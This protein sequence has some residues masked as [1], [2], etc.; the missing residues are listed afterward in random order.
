MNTNEHPHWNNHERHETTRKGNTRRR[1][2]NGPRG[3]GRPQGAPCGLSYDLFPSSSA[4]RALSC[5]SC[6]ASVL[7]GCVLLLLACWS[8]S[9]ATYYVATDGLNSSARDGSVS[10]PWG[11]LRYGLQS[12]RGGDTLVLRGGT[13]TESH[14]Y[15]SGSVQVLWKDGT[16]ASPTTI[17][18]YPSE[19]AVVAI[20]Q[21][22][23][24]TAF[25]FG[26]PRKWITLDGL[27]FSGANSVNRSVGVRVNMHNGVITN[28]QFI[29]WN[30]SVAL[31]PA[32]IPS[33][34]S[35]NNF[36]HDVQ[37]V[38]CTFSN[39]TSASVACYPFSGY[40]YTIER[41][42]FTHSNDRAIQFGSDCTGKELHGMTIRRNAFLPGGGIRFRAAVYDQIP[43]NTDVEIYNNIIVDCSGVRVSRGTVCAAITT[44]AAAS[45]IYN[46]TIVQT[47]SQ[48]REWLGIS[49][50]QQDA[51]IANNIIWG[52]FKYPVCVRDGRT[53]CITNTISGPNSNRYTGATIYSA[54]DW[55][56][57]AYDPLFEDSPDDLRIGVTG[58]ATANGVDLSSL[59]T[60]DYYGDT[61]T[62][63][64][65]IGAIIA[66]SDGCPKRN[67]N[68]R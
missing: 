30:A 39:I 57:S 18:N 4:F 46:N 33:T 42:L 54:N 56:G 28:C 11:T 1:P 10:Q 6:F 38:D 27:I 52:T 36:A 19:T 61:R 49:V 14:V 65:D 21:R 51:T 13:Y 58:W 26:S 3:S 43:S 24:G 55:N 60:T 53:A 62:T 45:K 25:G 66:G 15:E 41:N 44:A 20:T 29:N 8:S 40:H 67:R 37:I 59:F 32:G 9:A 5:A 48:T 2:H 35:T 22:S 7:L 12:M 16:E 50:R 17:K 31:Q 34:T 64:W 68:P 23:R 63:P 47:V